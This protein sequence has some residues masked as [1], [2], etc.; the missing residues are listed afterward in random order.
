MSKRTVIALAAVAA[1]L[2]AFIFFYERHLL[3]TGDVEDRA[4]RLLPTFVRDRVTKLEIEREGGRVVLERERAEGAEEGELGEWVLVEPVRADTDFDAVDSVLGA[5]EWADARR[6]IEG[7]SAQDRATFGLDEPRLRAFFTVAGER[8]PVAFGGEDPQASGVYASLGDE[9]IA[10]VVGKD[11]FEALDHDASW[12]RTKELL[13]E[14]GAARASRLRLEGAAGTRVLEKR[15]GQW[16]L[17]EP[18]EGWAAARAVNELLRGL[19]GLRA[20]RFVADDPESLA[21]Y[22]LDEPMHLA[23]FERPRGDGAETVEATLRIGRSCD[24][25]EGQVYARVDEGPVVCVTAESVAG[26]GKTAEELRESRLVTARDEEVQR[27]DLVSGN[28]RLELYRE[29]GEWKMRSRQGPREIEATADP[30]AVADFLRDARAVTARSFVRADDA[31][32]RERGLGSP[33]A[34]LTI[35]TPGEES[36][37]ETTAVVRVGRASSGTWARRGEEPTL[38]EID[39]TAIDVL[40]TSPTRFRARA[41]IDEH[42]AQLTRL[43]IRRRAEREVVERAD[44]GFRVVEPIAVAAD[45][46][47]MR[48][49]AGALAE[50]S[51]ERFVAEQ[52]APEHGLAQPRFVV[53]AR[54]EEPAGGDDDHGHDHGEEN[55]APEPA[56]DPVRNYL[57]RIGA[58]T[59]DGAYAR[60]DDDPAVFV[61]DRALVDAIER[62]VVDR[63]LLATDER[64]V[65]RIEIRR[66][67]ETITIAKQDGAWQENGAPAE[68]DRVE[69]LLR[70]LETLRATAATSYGPPDATAALARPRATV[71]VH[72]T[73]AA[74]EPREYTIAFGAASPP[75]VH[76]RRTDLDV[77][78]SI[79]ADVAATFVEY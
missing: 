42:D 29:E 76:V 23:H 53:E 35:V 19:E 46:A 59:D 47:V 40:D 60:L 51:A 38:L 6:T 63:G 14:A 65:A 5:L 73:D 48:A 13:V 39:E 55:D 79:P 70:R 43:A 64:H 41:V 34:T 8:V 32:V 57:V 77:G 78:F 33:V 66:G 16:W 2:A 68:R 24:E 21:Q 9:T 22:G 37:E 44:D 58:E 36:G 20:E 10:Y 67:A 7:V 28:R 72:R 56:R 15:G 26:L 54:F 30:Q 62:P 12:L 27:V 18:H 25:S 4:D 69:A 61:I 17:T 11:L 75:T 45:D 3:S 71:T 50:L 1:V 74:G 31:A 52:A 49:I